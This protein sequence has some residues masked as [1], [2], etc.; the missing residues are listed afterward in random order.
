MKFWCITTMLAVHRIF[1][2]FSLCD[3]IIGIS[4]FTQSF[5]TIQTLFQSNECGTLL[6]ITRMNGDRNRK[7]IS[8]NTYKFNRAFTVSVTAANIYI[9][10]SLC[11]L[12]LFS[13]ICS[14]SLRIALM[15]AFIL[16]WALR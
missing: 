11:L 8:R 1:R 9:A 4:K 12:L 16:E 7:A 2:I 10:Y 6:A 13:A 3:S 15:A 5:S 14:V